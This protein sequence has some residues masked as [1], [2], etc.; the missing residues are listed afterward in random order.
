VPA[1]R[2]DR[3]GRRDAFG[4]PPMPMHMSVRALC[5]AALMPPATSPSLIRRVPAPA[6]RI[7]SMSAR[8]A[9]G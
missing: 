3:A 6:S 4:L 5:R 7:S 8:G 2:L 1:E 9:A